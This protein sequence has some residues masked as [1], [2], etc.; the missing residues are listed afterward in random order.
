MW[1]FSR[2]DRAGWSMP[3]PEGKDRQCSGGFAGSGP[4]LQPIMPLDLPVKV[5]SLGFAGQVRFPVFE[6]ASRGHTGFAGS[7][8]VFTS[9]CRMASISAEGSLTC[10]G[11]HLNRSECE[12]VRP[13]SNVTST[14]R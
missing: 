5:R 4:V 13:S 3:Q 10:G 1:P 12:P 6:T 11:D 8:P 2:R 9:R 14:F 7:G